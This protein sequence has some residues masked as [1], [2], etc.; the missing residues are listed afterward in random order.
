MVLLILFSI[1]SLATS[2]LL[3]YFLIDISY[4]M[5]IVGVLSLPLTY[6][7]WAGIFIIFCFFYTRGTNINKELKK[8]SKFANFLVV[9]IE[10]QIKY[11]TKV[12]LK[13][14]NKDIMPKNQRY[15]IVCN[16][17]SAFD[18]ILIV[19]TSKNK[20]TICV[21]KKENI[22][23]PLFGRLLYKAGYI[24]LDRDNERQAIKAI[25]KASKYIADDK[26]SIVICPEGT[27]SKTGELGEFHAGSFKIATKVKCPIIVANITNVMDIKKRF[28]FKITKAKINY[29]KAL[30]YDDYK[31]MN[32][33]ELAEYCRNLIFEDQKINPVK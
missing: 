19:P 31:D 8:P 32:T 24:A 28:I 29:I 30:N 4:Y 22:E 2:G 10:L 3:T 13:V 7:L 15:L 26:Y 27:R 25:S 1:L 33:Q 18:P 11:L 20:P 9:Q 16:H 23:I 17:T 5:I 12:I 6:F 21:S 14:N